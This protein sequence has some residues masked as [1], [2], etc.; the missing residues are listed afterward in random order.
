MFYALSER[1]R[2]LVLHPGHRCRVREFLG[3][4]S[5]GGSGDDDG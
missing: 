5:G 4:D 2:V 1:P 3:G